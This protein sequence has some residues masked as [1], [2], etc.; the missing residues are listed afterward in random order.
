MIG[1][2]QEI[3]VMNLIAKAMETIDAE[4]KHR[5]AFWTGQRYGT[6]SIAPR[7]PTAVNHST[8]LGAIDVT[9]FEMFADLFDAASPNTDK[10]RALVAAYW[11]QICKGE[12]N[13]ASQT[14]NTNLKDLGHGVSNITL[15]LEHLKDE[16]PALVL[17]LK[18]SGAAKQARKTYKLTR[19][20][21]VR[22]QAMITK[23]E[24]DEQDRG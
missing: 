13:F 21:A 22:V 2:D 10:E 4:A 19:E 17:Q 12:A 20:G 6:G 3:E 23:E 5:V 8:S 1:P 24:M 18:K 14:L 7:P 11:T 15:A 9:S 16:R